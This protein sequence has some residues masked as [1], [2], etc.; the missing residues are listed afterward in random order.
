M[1]FFWGFG[2]R[3][4]T[5][6]IGEGNAVRRIYRY[7]H[8]FFVFRASWGGQYVLLTNTEAGWAQRAITN[9]EAEQLLGGH[10]LEPDLWNRFSLYAAVAVVVVILLIAH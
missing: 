10:K 1:I 2:R 8:L 6:Q 5:K 3:S 9:Q 7:F 4:I